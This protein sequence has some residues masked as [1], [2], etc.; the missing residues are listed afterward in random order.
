MKPCLLLVC[1]CLLS[2]CGQQDAKVDFNRLQQ[3]GIKILVVLQPLSYNG[4]LLPGLMDS[5]EK[6][7]PVSVT[8]S[9][10]IN[11]PANAWYPPRKRYKAD[12][13]LG[14]L[15]SIKPAQLRSVVGITDKDIS[16]KKGNNADYGI[17]GLGLQ[18][19]KVCVVS[20]FRLLK[21]NPTPALLFQRLLKTVLHEMGHNFGLPH[22][23]NKH[24]IMADAEGS[25]N[26][27]NETGLCEVCRKKIGLQ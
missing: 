23:P 20:T 15:Q 21:G 8:L 5:I 18:P 17:M 14:F 4:Q 12:S 19:G 9:T 3:K 26:Q 6:Y 11:L 1:Y 27:D 25:L 10:S 2:A 22:C 13:I 16:T 24:C 7:Y